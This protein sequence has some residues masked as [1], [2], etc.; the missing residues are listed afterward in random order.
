MKQIAGLLFL[1]IAFSS[2]YSYKIFPQ[3]YRRVQPP[4]EKENAYII[5]PELKKEKEIFAGSG[6]FNIV[7]DS[8]AA[9]KIKLYPLRQSWVCG[10]PLTASMLTLGQLPV[11]LTDRYFF[12]FDEINNG[13]L[14][15]KKYELR[16]AKRVWFWDMFVF[17]KNFN[18][19]AAQTLLGNYS[20]VPQQPLQVSNR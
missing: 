16:V 14:L 20:S 8:N 4:A 18:K 17:K 7:T 19:K 2:C 11:Y 12:E 13:R 5:N 9:V 15:N 3:E 1:A 10:Q 6:I